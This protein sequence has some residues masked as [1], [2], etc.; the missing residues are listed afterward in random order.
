MA[1]LFSGKGVSIV[2]TYSGLANSKIL[3]KRFLRVVS[4]HTV[5]SQERRRICLWLCRFTLGSP[6]HWI[7]HSINLQWGTILQNA[8]GA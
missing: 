5:V 7:T 2:Y 6:E 8:Q 4:E 3:L 1:D